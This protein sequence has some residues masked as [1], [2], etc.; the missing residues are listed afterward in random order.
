[1]NAPLFI[2]RRLSL[3]RGRGSGRRSPAVAIAVTG[4]A[5]SIAVM[6][7]TLA[8][9]PGFRDEVTRKVMG[10]DAQLTLQPVQPIGTGDGDIIP[11][12]CPPE[13]TALITDRYPGADVELAVKLPGILKTSDQFAGLVFQAFSGGAAHDFVAGNIIEGSMPDYAV[14]SLR[15]HIVIS[16]HTARALQVGVGDRIDGYFFNND[17]L[18]ARRF[19]IAGI[20]DSRFDDF[21]RLVAYMSL[22]A[23]RSLASL[24]PDEG[25]AVQIRNLPDGEVRQA[26]NVIGKLA[27][28]AFADGILPQYPEVVDV[29]TQNP[30]Y[31]N[32]LEL[33]NTNVAVIICL[34]GCV[35]A[36]TLISCLFIMILERVQLIGTLKALGAT[37]GQVARVFLYMAERVVIRGILVG[38]VIGMAI[39]LLQWRFRL[40]PLDPEAYYLSSVPVEF[41]WS[42]FIILNIAAALLSLVIMLLPAYTVS[43]IS[44][45]RAMRFE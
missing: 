13:F 1:M 18:R 22:T 42:G 26:R 43:R 6:I 27:G 25:T 21:D 14:D 29:Y 7:I 37:D 39:I 20:Y 28:T 38:D 9:V 12:V 31:F 32:W 24:G 11:A 17:N 16:S 2:S 10:F 41:N 40:I 44:P 15:Y 30:M 4:I 19:T 23:A 5:L 3:R 45:A 36:A 8:I 33:L 35:G 34:M